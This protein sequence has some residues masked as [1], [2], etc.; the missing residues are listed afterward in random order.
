MKIDI[1]SIGI[2]SFI[3]K[4]SKKSGKKEMKPQKKDNERT[5]IDLLRL[6]KTKNGL[7]R[8]V[9]DKTPKMFQKE[10]KN[11]KNFNLAVQQYKKD[12]FPKS[13]KVHHKISITNKKNM[14]KSLID[15]MSD[16]TQQNWKKVLVIVSAYTIF[17]G[18]IISTPVLIHHFRAQN[19]NQIDK[20]KERFLTL[21]LKL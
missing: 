6:E 21:F 13:S 8:S 4:K 20:F 17:V 15:L 11:N 14:K 3:V 2:D 12:Q 9:A 5:L 7:E 16:Y 10:L 1:V 18:A 19:Q